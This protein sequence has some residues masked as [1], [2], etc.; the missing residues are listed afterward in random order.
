MIMSKCAVPCFL[1][2]DAYKVCTFQCFRDSISYNYIS[3]YC[4]SLGMINKYV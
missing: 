3:T 4:N 2:F 1:F